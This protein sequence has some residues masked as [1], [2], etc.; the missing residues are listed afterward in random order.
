MNTVWAP[1][2]PPAGSVHRSSSPQVGPSKL[3]R[4]KRSSTRIFTPVANSRSPT[5]LQPLGPARIPVR[6]ILASLRLYT[7]VIKVLRGNKRRLRSTLMSPLSCFLQ[8]PDQFSGIRVL[9]PAAKL[10]RAPTTS[11]ICSS[12]MAHGIPSGDRLDS[13]PPDH[14]EGPCRRK[15]LANHI[16]ARDRGA[17]LAHL[18][19]HDAGLCDQGGG[20]TASNLHSVTSAPSGGRILI[21]RLA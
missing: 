1:L 17:V 4:G 11:D 18:G 8:K 16:C 19:D 9:V 21:G 2:S 15:A 14:I 20:P 13:G 5:T 12:A 6:Y 10:G 3:W 7:Q